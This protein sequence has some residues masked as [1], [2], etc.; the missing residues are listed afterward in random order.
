[1]TL[2]QW[3]TL[4]PLA[5]AVILLAVCGGLI[6]SGRIKA[7]AAQRVAAL[8]RRQAKDVTFELSDEAGIAFART[9]LTSQERRDIL[10]CLGLLE[11][12]DHPAIAGLLDPLLGHVAPEVR[13]EAARLAGDKRLESLAASVRSRLAIEDIPTTK[14]ALVRSL[15]ALCNGRAVEEVG[16]YMRDADP[17]VRRGALV[18]LITTGVVA[19]TAE[20]MRAARSSDVTERRMAAQ[21]A[22][23]LATCDLDP[24]VKTT[25]AHVVTAFLG[26]PDMDV[27]SAALAAAPRFAAPHAYELVIGNLAVPGVSRRAASALLELGEVAIPDLERV[28]GTKDL[29]REA[30]LRVLRILGA[31][32][33]PAAAAALQRQLDRGGEIVRHHA[34]AALRNCDFRANEATAPRY[35]EM[36]R[37]EALEATWTFAAI[38]DLGREAQTQLVRDALHSKVLRH[39]ERIFTILAFLYPDDGIADM[40][41]HFLRGPS[42]K[43]AYALE[44]LEGLLDPQHRTLLIPVL[45]DLP[46][47]AKLRALETVLP[48]AHMGRD[49]RLRAIV[50]RSPA[51]ISSWICASAL[52]AM[53]SIDPERFM[54]TFAT[55]TQTEDWLVCETAAWIIERRNRPGTRSST[56]EKAVVLKGVDIFASLREEFLVDVASRVWELDAA[57]GET[58]IE[59]GQTGSSLYIIVEGSVRLLGIDQSLTVLEKGEVFGELMALDPEPRTASITAVEATRFYRLDYEDLDEVMAVDLDVSRSIIRMLC[60]RIRSTAKREPAPALA[61]SRTSSNEGA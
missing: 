34:L 1:M 52:Y 36:L 61:A 17:I 40:W 29:N 4:W 33:T 14:S 27:R 45:E 6:L 5:L 15:A 3:F 7:F 20:I 31:M 55:A 44:S 39:Q 35:A 25:I 41:A 16:P 38:D 21:V 30:R 58:I 37:E 42:E 12:I 19:A 46:V 8:A 26:D 49:D 48:Q 11:R 32:R 53:D 24:G 57:P 43:R 60:R 56:I 13:A 18:G 23:D 59:R 54:E 10:Y 9:M 2:G 51:L 22:A 28:L 47:Q 50:G